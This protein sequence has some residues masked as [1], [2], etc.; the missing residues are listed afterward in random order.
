MHDNYS[1]K[2]EQAYWRKILR[3]YMGKSN[4]IAFFQVFNTLI[5]FLF[6][7]IIYLKEAMRHPWVI[8]ICII[9]TIALLMR[10]FVLMHDCGHGN[11][12][13]GPRLNK[14][15]GYIFGVISGMPQYVWS[16]NHVYH[17]KT[18]G[19]WERYH[20]PLNIV[21][22]EKYDTFTPR[23]K[24]FYALFRHPL[25]FPMSGFFYILFNPRYNFIRDSI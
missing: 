12:F 21:S 18:N 19:D 5:P 8:P 3:P 11:L 10:F 24:N 1:L 15:F 14:I 20:G 6:I 25:T 13:K 2:T 23:Q 7:W 4:S 22:T 16:R 17:H 9:L